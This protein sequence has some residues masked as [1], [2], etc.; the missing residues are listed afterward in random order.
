MNTPKAPWNHNYA[1]HGWIAK[2]VGQRRKILDVGCP[3]TPSDTACTT[4]IC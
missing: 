4:G 2:A 3:G 1:Y